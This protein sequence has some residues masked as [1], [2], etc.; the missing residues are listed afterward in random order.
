M[1]MLGGRKGGSSNAFTCYAIL[2]VVLIVIIIV[3]VM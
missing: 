1:P 2:G 3:V